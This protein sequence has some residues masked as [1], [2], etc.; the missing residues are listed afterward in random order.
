MKKTK[1]NSQQKSNKR[2]SNLQ[3]QQE[4]ELRAFFDRHVGEHFNLG[5][6]GDNLRVIRRYYPALKDNLQRLVREKYIVQ[7]DGK[8]LRRPKEN[9]LVGELRISGKGAG[10]VKIPL[11]G[12]DIF[13]KARDLGRAFG[14][15][16]VV[17]EVLATRHEGLREGKIVAVEKRVA[18]RFPGIYQVARFYTY[19][20]PVDR[21]LQHEFLIPPG[22]EKG[23]KNGQL[24]VFELVD[25]PSGEINPTGRVVEVLGDPDDPH[26][27][28]KALQI[29]YGINANFTREV[30]SAAE[31]Q[32]LAVTAEI[33]D[34]RLDLRDLL[35]FTIDPDDAKDFD[36]AVSLE[37]LDNGNY[38]L[39][40]HIADVSHFVDE[41]S[42]LDEEAFNRGCSVYLVD[43]VI[44][45]LPEYLSNKLCSL[46]PNVDR[47]TYS[48]FMEL[49]SDFQLVSYELR[50]AIINSKRRYT[51]EE[52]QAILDGQGEDD[53]AAVIRDMWQLAKQLSEIRLASGAMDFETPEVKFVL[54]NKG[55][56]KEIIPKQRLQSMRLIEE[57]MLMANKTVAWH[58]DWIGENRPDLPFIYRVH[59]KPNREKVERF[60]AFMRAIGYTV[61]S[62]NLGDAKSFQA[63]IDS[64]H[65]THETNLVE[66]IALRSMM[67]A[68]YSTANIGHYGL[69][70]SH[71]T[72]FTSPIRRYPDLWVHRL[73]KEY[74]QMVSK[75]R[76]SNL[77]RRLAGVAEHSTSMEITAQQ[78][79]RDSIKLKQ[80]EYI[81]GYIGEEFNGVISGVVEFGLFV[82][83][84]AMLIEGLIHIKD[85]QDDYYIFDERSFTLTGRS[86]KLVFRI[87]DRLRIKVAAVNVEARNIDYLLVEALPNDSD[88]E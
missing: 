53:N 13:V 26:V 83:L 67:K 27:Q 81:S 37:I 49:D 21:R 64:V 62:E 33:L 79:E 75:E 5:A 34:N 42:P 40:V 85:L 24:V 41:G 55:F 3:R 54:D 57:F 46:Q 88:A 25:W 74:D 44:P 80:I 30:L 66:E 35:T 23:A 20:A 69:G 71:Y 2:R 28:Q 77:R 17:V 15:D 65:G 73:L 36:D 9:L 6:I 43:R 39:G 14:G 68:M 86:K 16:T 70:F 31:E 8:Y 82:S 1:K 60:V 12:E 51:Y 61:R 29:S 11:T 22:D 19:T 48:C 87:G 32:Q 10:F 58:I 59:E 78:A 47:L 38:Y 7:I 76:L 72:H 84:D 50:P 18:H 4:R 45:M 52:V 56:P 63:V